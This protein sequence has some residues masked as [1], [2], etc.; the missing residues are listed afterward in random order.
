MFVRH[1]TQDEIAKERQVNTAE[2]RHP[3]T[4][5]ERAQRPEWLVVVG[6][7]THLGCVPIGIFNIFLTIIF[8]L[9]DLFLS[10]QR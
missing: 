4:D 9:F 8:H 2:L 1:R 10:G 5:E 7:C 3:Q 6:V